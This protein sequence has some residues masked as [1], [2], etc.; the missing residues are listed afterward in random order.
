MN[1]FQFVA[2]HQRRHGVKRL[3]DILGIA[4]SSF[5]YWRRTA[6]DRAGRQ[7]AD[8]R[9]ADRIRAVHRNRTAP[10]GPRGSPPSSVRR[11]VRRSTTSVS[12]GSCGRPE[13]KRSAC[14]VGTAPPSPTRRGQGAGPDRPR[15]HRRKP[16]HEVRRRHHLPAHPRREVLLSRDRDRPRLTPSGR[17]GHRRP[18][19]RGS[20]HRRPGGSGPNPRQPHRVDHAH[21]PRS[22]VHEQGLLRSMQVSRGPTEYECGRVQRGQR[23]RGVLQRDLQTRD[24]PGPKELAQRA[25]GPTR[26]LPMAQ[27]LQHPT[28]ALPPRTPQPHHLRSRTRSTTNYAGISHITRVQDPGSRPEPSYAAPRSFNVRSTTPTPSPFHDGPCPP[29]RCLCLAGSSVP[30]LPGRMSTS[31]ES[32]TPQ[33]GRS[34]VPREH[35]SEP[36][37]RPLPHR[38]MPGRPATASRRHQ[39]AIAND[40]TSPEIPAHHRRILGQWDRCSSHVGHAHKRS[41]SEGASAMAEARTPRPKSGSQGLAGHRTMSGRGMSIRPPQPAGARMPYGPRGL[42]P[43]PD[44][45]KEPL[46]PHPGEGSGGARPV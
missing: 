12:P 1:R 5:Y 10:T 42:P 9:L 25:P 40:Q 45:R 34:P 13:S 24:T 22:P 31:G 7:A 39:A 17:V 23:S 28:P 8:A 33:G 2:D 43:R 38:P 30:H 29:G 46:L 15:L 32:A 37:L 44:V 3:C 11:A 4:R 6:A 20:C 36:A 26:R 18:H 41:R 35:S 19:A 14:S 16:E 27:P 21:R